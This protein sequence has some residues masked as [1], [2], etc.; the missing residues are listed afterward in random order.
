MDF[1]VRLNQVEIIFGVDLYTVTEHIGGEMVVL[2]GEVCQLTAE[3]IV[4]IG[5]ELHGLERDVG[6]EKL[7]VPFGSHE[8]VL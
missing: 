7:F 1:G 3:R 5:L 6:E 4:G 8:I 2:L